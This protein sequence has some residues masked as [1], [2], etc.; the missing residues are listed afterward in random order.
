MVDVLKTLDDKGITILTELN[1]IYEHEHIPGMAE[2][3]FIQLPT[4]NLQQ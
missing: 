1:L 2:S 4:R 3:V